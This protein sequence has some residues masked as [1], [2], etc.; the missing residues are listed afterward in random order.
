MNNDI[1]LKVNNLKTFFH[2]DEGILK[3]VDDV[4]LTV[5]KKK[6]LG[7]IGESGCACPRSLA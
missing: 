7:I 4:S 5:R 3:A 6:T 1:V 2:L